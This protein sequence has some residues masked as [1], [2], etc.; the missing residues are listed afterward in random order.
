MMGNLVFVMIFVSKWPNLASLEA[1][2]LKTTLIVSSFFKLHFQ[3]QV[4]GIKI[5][6]KIVI[7]LRFNLKIRILIKL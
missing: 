6:N 4:V 7:E 3:H 2:M 5:N 1:K